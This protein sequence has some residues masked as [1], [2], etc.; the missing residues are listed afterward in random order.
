M[1]A[2]GVLGKCATFS[3]LKARDEVFFHSLKLAAGSDWSTT[4]GA[5]PTRLVSHAERGALFRNS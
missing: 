4:P 5:P 2:M 3:Y 1:A